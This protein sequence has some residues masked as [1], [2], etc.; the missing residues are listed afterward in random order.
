MRRETETLPSFSSESLVNRD[1]LQKVRMMIQPGLVR[2][3]ISYP[4]PCPME[5]YRCPVHTHLSSDDEKFPGLE[6]VHTAAAWMW[7]LHCHCHMVKVGWQVVGGRYSEQCE[8]RVPLGLQQALA[9]LPRRIGT[10]VAV[11]ERSHCGRGR[12][13]MGES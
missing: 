8:V 1:R 6:V 13:R 5:D 2:C 11:V 10:L 4:A 3:G 7:H 9:Q 12:T